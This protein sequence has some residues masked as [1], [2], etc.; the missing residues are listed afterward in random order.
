M[1][2]E[3]V[4]VQ[5]IHATK[6]AFAAL[7]EGGPVVTWGSP[8]FG[9]DSTPVQM[10]LGSNVKGVM[11]A[12]FAFAA[13]LDDGSVAAWGVPDTGGDTSSVQDELENVRQIQATDGAF[14]ALL[15]P[16]G[17]TDMNPERVIGRDYSIIL[18]G[19]YCLKT[20][21]PKPPKP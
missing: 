5:K 16:W 8:I 2:R 7:L 3:L 11:A 20:L 15:E 13:L 18:E 17:N 4:N 9:G 10:Q 12:G 14:A 1:Q 6:Y 19:L 21:N